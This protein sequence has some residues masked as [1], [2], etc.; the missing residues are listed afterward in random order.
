MVYVYTHGETVLGARVSWMHL[1]WAA[2]ANQTHGC[3]LALGML[4]KWRSEGTL[5]VSL[6]GSA[7]ARVPVEL[8]EKIRLIAQYA[9]HSAMEDEELDSVDD[10]MCGKCK[11]DYGGQTPAWL[12]HEHWEEVPQYL[13]ESAQGCNSCPK[14]AKLVAKELK[15]SR[16]DVADFLAEYGLAVEGLQARPDPK[17]CSHHR[18]S[19]TSLPTGSTASRDGIDGDEAK[20][21][22]EVGDSAGQRSPGNCSCPCSD[23][24][25]EREDLR[26]VFIREDLENL[27]SWPG[28]T[29]LLIRSAGDTIFDPAFAS[30]ESWW[31]EPS[32]GYSQAY[33]VDELRELADE[34]DALFQRFFDDWP[35]AMEVKGKL[36]RPRRDE[37][38]ARFHTRMFSWSD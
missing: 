31:H 15:K 3:S 6:K 36:R 23:R 29:V 28:A 4:A 5:R 12:D 35:V 10:A 30:T 11:E 32:L 20:K 37:A 24:G 7:I 22:S 34:H 21:T 25:S 19:S 1:C 13:R 18:R 16:F 33:D 2:Y 27:I 17:N 9:Q 26:D 8:W 14:G 38:V